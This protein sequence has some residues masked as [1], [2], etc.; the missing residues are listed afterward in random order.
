LIKLPSVHA[1]TVI[2]ARHLLSLSQQ[3]NF[4]E[5]NKRWRMIPLE[6]AEEFQQRIWQPSILIINCYPHKD[7]ESNSLSEFTSVTSPNRNIT[8]NEQPAIKR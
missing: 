4:E 2:T 5:E 7:V 8:K 3:E 1:V 6:T